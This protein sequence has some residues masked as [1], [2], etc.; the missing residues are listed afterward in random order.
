MGT[1]ID[2]SWLQDLQ[3]EVARVL[4]TTNPQL[5]D[6]LVEW[7]HKDRAYIHTPMP[8]HIVTLIRVK[9]SCLH[10]ESPEAMEQME[11]EGGWDGM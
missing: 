8:P 11:Q 2:S 4:T 10:K 5:P 7:S 3:E 9:G 6:C 1:V